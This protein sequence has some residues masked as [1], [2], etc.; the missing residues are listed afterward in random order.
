[1]EVIIGID[2]GKSGAIAVLTP[3][4]PDF[5]KLK[6]TEKDVS[7]FLKDFDGFAFIEN[8]NSSPQMGVVSAF[9]F[10]QSKGFLRGLLIALEIPFEEVSPQKWQGAMKCRTKGDKN[11]TKAKAQELFPG[12]KITH[13]NAD[14]LLIAEYGRRVRNGE[15]V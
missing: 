8:V 9:K 5:I 6:E 2:P 12:L 14:A 7:D 1:M 11:I 4:G 10:G 13:A 3:D 15:F